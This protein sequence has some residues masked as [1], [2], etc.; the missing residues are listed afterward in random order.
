MT[1]DYNSFLIALAVSASCLAATLFGSWFGRRTE[2]FL[3]SCAFALLLIV[4]GIVVY[5]LCVQNPGRWLGLVAYVLFHSGFAIGWVRDISFPS[6]A[7]AQAL[8]RT[9]ALP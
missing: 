7:C 5:G 9:S 4:G 2:T 1:L 6:R 8:D 3:L